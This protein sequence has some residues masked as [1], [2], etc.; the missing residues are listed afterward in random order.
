MGMVPDVGSCNIFMKVQPP[1]H[2]LVK[3]MTKESALFYNW[4]S[5]HYRHLWQQKEILLV[6]FSVILLCLYNICLFCSAITTY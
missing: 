4:C 2:K 6:Y 5:T 3:V 1:P